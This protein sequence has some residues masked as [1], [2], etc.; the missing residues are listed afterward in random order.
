MV[1][2]KEQR[3]GEEK[4]KEGRKR[5]KVGIQADC[6][7]SEHKADTIS[8]LVSGGLKLRSPFPRYQRKRKKNRESEM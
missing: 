7:L 2:Y 8:T 1:K 4:C 6:R 3:R 5:E